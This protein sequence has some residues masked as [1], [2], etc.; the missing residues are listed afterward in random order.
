MNTEA[1]SEAMSVA[2]LPVTW[3]HQKVD[4]ARRDSLTACGGSM[5]LHFG[6]PVGW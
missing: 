5:G 6:L 4:E 2:E 1:E 3:S